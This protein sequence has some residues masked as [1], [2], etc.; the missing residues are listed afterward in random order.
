MYILYLRHWSSDDRSQSVRGLQR[1]W[2]GFDMHHVTMTMFYM[3]SIVIAGRE[4]KK[5]DQKIPMQNLHKN[6]NEPATCQSVWGRW[7]KGWH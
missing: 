4:V 1:K 3:Y 5:G 7:G 2:V 6:I